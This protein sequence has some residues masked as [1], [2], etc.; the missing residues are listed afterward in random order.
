[1]PKKGISNREKSGTD[2]NDSKSKGHGNQGPIP[3]IGLLYFNKL[4]GTG[5][6]TQWLL[7]L[8]LYVGKHYG[9]AQD[10]IESGNKYVPARI[11]TPDPDD[12]DKRN[13][14]FGIKL[15]SY[16]KQEQRRDAEMAEL[17]Q[18]Y[19]RIYNVILGQLSREST[20]MVKQH[21]D[22]LQADAVKDPVELIAIIRKTHLQP[23]TGSQTLD[24][25]TAWERYYG[26]HQDPGTMLATHKKSFDDAVIALEATG[27][28]KPSEAKLAARFIASLDP[29]RYA[30]WKVEL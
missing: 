15:K 9:R 22:W 29:N 30:Q 5:N 25:D 17:E 28:K 7:Q 12:F 23:M 27:E 18:L 8:H 6:L 26:L 13:D 11:P 3:E 14:P 19:P 4:K 20:E 16:Q 10:F 24:S 2:K 21:V 1:M